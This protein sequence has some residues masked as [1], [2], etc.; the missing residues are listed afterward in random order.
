M[1]V[2]GNDF[3]GNDEIDANSSSATVDTVHQQSQK[4]QKTQEVN[5]SGHVEMHHQISQHRQ[6]SHDLITI[7]PKEDEMYCTTATRRKKL[8][9]NL[10][11]QKNCLSK[12]FEGKLGERSPKIA[13]MVAR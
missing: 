3:C 7:A 5:V 10:L 4:T 8:N 13:L 11:N 1:N 9:I 12:N 6:I 2:C